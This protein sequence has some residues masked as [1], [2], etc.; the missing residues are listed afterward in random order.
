LKVGNIFLFVQLKVNAAQ[1]ARHRKCCGLFDSCSD[2]YRRQE[3]RAPVS[4]L[5][6]KVL[7]RALLQHAQ[8]HRAFSLQRSDAQSNSI[9]DTFYC[10]IYLLELGCCAEM[11][12]VFIICVFQQ[13]CFAAADVHALPAYQHETQHPHRDQ[14]KRLCSMMYI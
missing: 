12:K 6:V 8:Q 7:Q 14:T 9:Y 3:E 1:S 2:N 4:L 13:H 11:I 10:S 5:T